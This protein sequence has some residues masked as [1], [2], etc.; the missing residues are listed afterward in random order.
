MNAIFPVAVKHF[1]AESGYARVNFP[2]SIKY[3]A[4]KHEAH[5]KFTYYVCNAFHVLQWPHNLGP[6][7]QVCCQNNVL[8]LCSDILL[9]VWVLLYVPCSP[10]HIP[11]SFAIR[12]LKQSSITGKVNAVA[13]LEYLLCKSALACLYAVP[14]AGLGTY[15]VFDDA[16]CVLNC[17]ISK[18]FHTAIALQPVAQVIHKYVDVC[19]HI[20]PVKCQKKVHLNCITSAFHSSSEI[21]TFS[22]IARALT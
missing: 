3:H 14:S 19:C 18:A 17:K 12:E 16:V 7:I 20:L 6:L 15:D 9:H 13:C 21:V 22:C 4:P 8:M 5:I 2:I 10:R 11:S 1:G